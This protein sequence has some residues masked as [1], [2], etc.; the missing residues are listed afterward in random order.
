MIIAKSISSY[1]QK[2]LRSIYIYVANNYLVI[3]AFLLMTLI[4][5]LFVTN[6]LYLIF[7]IL[8]FII[9]LILI[10]DVVR[11]TW[12]VYVSM[13]LFNFSKT[14]TIDYGNPSYYLN[15]IGEIPNITYFVS[16][17]DGILLILLYLILFKQVKIRKLF[18]PI[19]S[20]EVLAIVF[21]SI[22][23]ISANYSVIPSVAW[24][25][26]FQVVKYLVVFYVAA[27]LAIQEKGILRDTIVLFLLFC[28]LN[29]ALIIFQKIFG[30]PIGLKIENG[31]SLYGKYAD[32][33]TSLYRPGGMY[34]DP[35]LTAT[36]LSMIIPVSV[37]DFLTTTSES[38]KRVSV[39]LISIFSIALLFTASRAVWVITAILILLSVIYLKKISLFVKPKINSYALYATFGIFLLLFG[40]LFI[41]RLKSLGSTL[42]DERGGLQYR[43]SH[44]VLSTDLMLKRPFGVGMN[45]FQYAILDRYDPYE[46]FSDSTA[47]HNLFAEI[48]AGAG[49]IGLFFF[50]LLLGRYGYMLWTF[51]FG[52]KNSTKKP[53]LIGSIFLIA[54]Y[55]LS[56]QFYPLLFSTMIT[57]FF[58]I[59]SGILYAH[60]RSENS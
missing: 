10:R 3:G 8:F 31:F 35:N 19:S 17:A 1:S 55:L 12:L 52:Q 4:N 49:I 14:F 30:G 46:Y 5:L 54:A 58:F 21:V 9:N 11:T 16:F 37:V 22:V 41:S 23:M 7:S 38:K 44:I 57:T 56:A 48:G 50:C 33:S 18:P 29:A 24:F 15:L 43:L 42:T 32:E 34:W 36:L 59:I 60:I 45:V 47:A 39:L 13:L 2:F 28:L 53:L 27:V 40:Q 26:S 6:K 20:F 25:F 51:M